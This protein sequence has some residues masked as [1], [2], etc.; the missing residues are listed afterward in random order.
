MIGVLIRG[1][2]GAKAAT[3]SDGTGGNH[4]DLSDGEGGGVVGRRRKCRELHGWV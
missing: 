4:R 1:F 3:H 2:G